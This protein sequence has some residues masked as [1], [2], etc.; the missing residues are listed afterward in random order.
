[1]K[2]IND[3]FE[4]KNLPVEAQDPTITQDDFKFVQSDAKIH[5][6]KFETK[7]TTFLK[8]CLKRF[9][10]NKSSVVAAFILG[11]LLIL[12]VAVPLFGKTNAIHDTKGFPGIEYL[13]PRLF[14]PGTGFWDGTKK[15][16]GIA[17]DTSNPDKSTWGP[18]TKT[19]EPNAISNLKI[20]EEDYIKQ[21][22]DCGKDGYVQISY[23]DNP[24]FEYVS[25]A[26]KE[27]LE[28]YNFVKG[29]KITNFV[30]LSKAEV[31]AAET[32]GFPEGYAEAESALFFKF[33]QGSDSYE[34]ELAPYSVSH[35]ISESNAVDI[36]AKFDELAA[37]ESL[38]TEIEHPTFEI[39]VKVANPA[40]QGCALIRSVGISSEEAVPKDKQ[41]LEGYS[42]VD[43]NSCMVRKLEENSYWKN[44]S[45]FKSSFVEVY[46]PKG[47]LCSFTYDTYEAALGSFSTDLFTADLDEYV[48]RKWLRYTIT[49]T[50]NEYGEYVVDDFTFE[51]TILNAE[52]CP[53]TKPFTAEDVV[54]NKDTG[55]IEKIKCFVDNYKLKP[56]YL[57]EM[58]SFILGTDE[59][60]KDMFIYVFEGLR[61][62]LILGVATTIIC[63]LFGLLWGSICGYFGGTVDLIMERF[64]DILS[65]VPW[66]VV[67]TLVIIKAETAN[68]GVF[69]L[70]L[71]LTGWIGTAATTRTQFYRFRGREYV[72]AS[73]TL[74]ASHGRLIA[75]HILP[76]AMGTIIT[77][78]VL[79]VPSIIFEEATLSFL[80]LAKIGGEDGLSSL[81]VILSNNQKEL[82]NHP[83]LLIFPSVVIALIMISFNLFGNGLRDAV[84]PS[85][86]GEGE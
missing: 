57:T 68:F 14:E 61:T 58:P 49:D 86:K 62:S 17:V 19:F 74:G 7:P 82:T 85:L 11:F 67:M 28:K 37:A 16:T 10:K 1:M 45:N 15:M 59:N 43:G 78:A 22:I 77:S 12:S 56:F 4:L 21:A 79:M 36:K 73:R 44:Y 72:L 54:M 27:T 33:S 8:D 32:K 81:G 30:T 55:R 60:G 53:L 51:C 69:A 41:M 2:K 20:G 65:G 26:T 31:E 6:Q 71:C 35:N 38:S 29:L 75:K 18:N 46:L 3:E 83:Y 66:I 70:A 64:T 80:G 52:K 50:Q 47:V 5:D 48:A 13:E 63:F 23:F 9:A 84:N 24:A 25:Y 39:R 40:V 76:N 42:F 34:I